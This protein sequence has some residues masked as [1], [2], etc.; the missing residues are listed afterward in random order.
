MSCSRY[1]LYRIVFLLCFNYFFS[2]CIIMSCPILTLYI[3]QQILIIEWK[4]D[5]IFFLL[6]EKK[7]KG[8]SVLYSSH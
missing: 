2:Y 4:I 6:K 5:F 3:I 7:R 1:F 8:R